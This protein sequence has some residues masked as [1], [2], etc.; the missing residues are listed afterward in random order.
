MRRA[1]LAGYTGMPWSH[2]SSFVIPE[3]TRRQAGFHFLEISPDLTP[4]DFPIELV[5]LA[6][7]GVRVVPRDSDLCLGN[8][9]FPDRMRAL[10]LRELANLAGSP[11]VT[12]KMTMREAGDA[13]DLCVPRTE[14]ALDRVVENVRITQDQ[15][16]RPVAL[17]I[18]LSPE[19]WNRGDV[20]EGPF[21]ESLTSRTG[22]WIV[23]DLTRVVRFAAQHQRDPLDMLLDLPLHR[24][25]YMRVVSTTQE[26]LGSRV[27]SVV[28]QLAGHPETPA[29]IPLLLES[30]RPP[31]ALQHE[32]V[33]LGRAMGAVTTDEAG[34][35]RLTS[36]PVRIQIPSSALAGG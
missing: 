4:E 19:R 1:P 15:V 24:M 32:L 9:C 11:L 17:E 5:Q 22:C 26:P 25:A 6:E 18:M 34:G 33:R 35:E 16:Q 29:R 13:R 20:P 3:A 10:R 30:S 31:V 12:A 8:R 27:L 2:T 7:D 14:E 21:L 28:S 23:M 36:T